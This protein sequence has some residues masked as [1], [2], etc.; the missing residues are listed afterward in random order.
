M[1]V[2]IYDINQLIRYTATFT[3]AAGVPTDPTTIYLHISLRTPAA[4]TSYQFGV[5]SGLIRDSAG[6]YHKD[7]VPPGPGIVIW[8]WEGNGAVQTGAQDAIEVMGVET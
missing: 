1:A 3:N 2:P 5:D 4:T 8:R 6:V 7:I